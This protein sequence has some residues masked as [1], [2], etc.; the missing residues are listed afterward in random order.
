MGYS[1][2]NISLM[3]IVV[4]TTA[5]LGSS[6]K[7]HR[8]EMSPKIQVNKNKNKNIIKW[9]DR[10]VVWS[11]HLVTYFS[12]WRGMRNCHQRKITT[13][14]NWMVPRSVNIFRNSKFERYSR[15]VHLHNELICIIIDALFAG[16]IP[17]GTLT[18]NKRLFERKIATSVENQSGYNWRAINVYFDSGTSDDILPQ[19]VL[20]GMQLFIA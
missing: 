8:P 19:T 14:T 13:I 15:C 11:W 20:K 18:R 4:G 6:V 5:V 9:S 16:V 2:L 17:A 7:Q 1:K 3:L 10:F 12:S